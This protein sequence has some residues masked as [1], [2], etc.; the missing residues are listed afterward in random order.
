MDALMSS[1]PAVVTEAEAA[2][3]GREAYLFLYPLLVMEFTRRV[4]TNV[5]PDVRIGAGPMNAFSHARIFPPAD[6]RDVVRPNFDTLY[7]VAWLDLH[8][9]PL[10][11]SAPDTGGRY[12]LLPMLD[13]WSNVFAVP[14]K[15]TTGTAAAHFALV[16]RGWQ[17]SLPTGVE[18]IEAPT[19]YVWVI[20]RTQT[21]GA[22][23]YPAVHAV[24]DGY[25]IT[26]L[27]R[28]GSRRNRCR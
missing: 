12:Y 24:Q 23:D 14:G 28:W 10:I 19:A 22:A 5:P 16:P 4:M 26:P 21:N 17:G 7:S 25:R 18:P 27:S 9:E 15:R 2:M 11:V 1:P 13:M 8:N 6:F 20:G 3:I